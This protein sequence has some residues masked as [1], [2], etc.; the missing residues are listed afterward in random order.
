MYLYPCSFGDMNAMTENH[1][2]IR[3]QYH[4]QLIHNFHI[5]GCLLLI[6][7]NITLIMQITN[8]KCYFLYN[9]NAYHIYF[10]IES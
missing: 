6:Y 2:A 7:V 8:D 9:N 10:E 1:D 5:G 3:L 4:H